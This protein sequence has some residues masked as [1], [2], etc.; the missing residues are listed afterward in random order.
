[1]TKQRCQAGYD[2]IGGKCE[3]RGFPLP[4]GDGEYRLSRRDDFSPRDLVGV[5]DGEI[6]VERHGN[7]YSA[8]SWE[9]AKRWVAE[10]IKYHSDVI[11]QR[12]KEIKEYVREHHCSRRRAEEKIDYYPE[13]HLM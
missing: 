1:M 4:F 12:D 3:P 8:M 7:I 5:K 10:S 2:M 11:D 6:I 13:F 9:S